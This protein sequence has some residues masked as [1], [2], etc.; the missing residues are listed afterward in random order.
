[1]IYE[2]LN[3]GTGMKWMCIHFFSTMYDKSTQGVTMQPPPQKKG[4]H[5]YTFLQSHAQFY[6]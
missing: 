2:R 5:G 1:M 6:F 4:V 3:N